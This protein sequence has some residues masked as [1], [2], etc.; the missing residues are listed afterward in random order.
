MLK[1]IENNLCKTNWL[2]Q[3]RVQARVLQELAACKTLAKHK[4]PRL[5]QGPY[6]RLSEQVK[7]NDL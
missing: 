1:V 3:P 5:S 2:A 7:Q 6:A 4:G